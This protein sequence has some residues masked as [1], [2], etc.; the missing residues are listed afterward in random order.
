MGRKLEDIFN[1]CYQRLLQGESI[2]SC[3]KSYPK[4]AAKLE[5]LL[6]VATSLHK[7]A[8][9][10]QARPEFKWQARTRIEG[11]FLYNQQQKLAKAKTG[12]NWQRS[13]ALAVTTILVVLMVGVGTAAASTQAMPDEI[14]YPVKMATEQAQI[15]L[16][17]SDTARAELHARLAEKRTGE[18]TQMAAQNKPIYIVK[19]TEQLTAHLDEAEIYVS[20]QV[21]TQE[22][23]TE[24]PKFATAPSPAP[25]PPSESAPSLT[26]EA[27]PQGEQAEPQTNQDTQAKVREY[28]VREYLERSAAR[29]IAAL[30]LA[31]QQ[32]PE[33]AKP[34][35]RLALEIT[36]KRYERLLKKLEER[37]GQLP[38][39]QAETEQENKPDEENESNSNSSP[40]EGNSHE[41]G[42]TKPEGSSNGNKEEGIAPSA[43][44]S[45]SDNSS[46]SENT[47]Q[48]DNSSQ[49]DS[50]AP[51]TP[52]S[53]P[54]NAPNS[55]ISL[56][57]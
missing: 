19:V 55:E 20:Q 57:E 27:P 36:K 34:A 4:E 54:Q 31:L 41:K 30:E 35:L 21:E 6:K 51:L 5:P 28:K 3:L 2:E 1:E 10:I 22:P 32:A 29:N 26:E 56:P 24:A 33:E 44:P 25:A 42:K 37:G 11:A 49:N 16:T 15:N 38:T 17:L 7:K 52:P 50:E 18:I 43:P 8:T 53:P 48:S 9:S 23:A 39:P 45:P 40:S 13:W 46:Q 47:T 12:F 14:L